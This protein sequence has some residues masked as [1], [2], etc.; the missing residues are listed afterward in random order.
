[1]SVDIQTDISREAVHGLSDEPV[2]ALRYDWSGCDPYE[3][4]ALM[5]SFI[6]P[7]SRVLDIGCGTG[8]ITETIMRSRSAEVV[9]IEP[10]KERAE[11][12]RQ[13]GLEIVN[14]VYGREIPEK[15]G[16]FDYIVFGDVLEHLED[17][18]AILVSVADALADNGRVIAS[19]PNVAHWSVRLN[20]LFGRFDY[21][22]MGIM[23]ATHLRW[24]T[25]KSVMRLFHA[26]GYEVEAIKHSAGA[27]L[28]QYK[29]TPLR[30]LPMKYRRMVI[31]GLGDISHGLF[32]CQHV[33]SARRG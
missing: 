3:S 15:Y 9:G 30:A 16:K 11:A 8:T 7:G 12:A 25:R 32:A 23:D 33:I 26:T 22:P 14:G 19:I 1:V 5:L 6:K 17:P 20:L 4:T 27:W 10:N 21:T 18:A 28:P 2:S 24:F 31:S 29:W 13:R